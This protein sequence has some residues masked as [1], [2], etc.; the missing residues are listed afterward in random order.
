MAAFAVENRH[1]FD[2]GTAAR[3]LLG[4]AYVFQPKEKSEFSDF[5]RGTKI[6]LHSNFA[7]NERRGSLLTITVMDRMASRFIVFEPYY[8]TSGHGPSNG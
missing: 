7:N 3:A 1:L 5:S 8:Q 2:P 4:L 6:G